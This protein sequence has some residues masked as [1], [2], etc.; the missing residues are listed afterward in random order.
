MALSGNWQLT[1][2][3]KKDK[4][5][6]FIPTTLQGSLNIQKVLRETRPASSMERQMTVK[7]LMRVIDVKIVNVILF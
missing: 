1:W 2:L 5:F 4:A 7:M 3:Q 6:A